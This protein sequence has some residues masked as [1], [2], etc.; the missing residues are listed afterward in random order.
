M[1]AAMT[2][3]ERIEISALIRKRERVMR[4]AAAERAAAMLAAFEQQVASE[5]HFADDAVWKEATE[6]AQAVVNEAKAAIAARCA[7]LGIPKEFAPGI[8][9]GWYGQGQNA[10]K[11]RVAELRRV[12]RS[13]VDALHKE[14]LTK[15]EQASLDAQSEV[16]ISGLESNAAKLFLSNMKSVDELMPSIGLADV[17]LLIGARRGSA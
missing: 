10:V 12:A 9:L 8:S 16:V 6:R 13:R 5:Y 17:T 15:I 7:E 3:Q 11:E 14:A 4:A 1:S 2:K